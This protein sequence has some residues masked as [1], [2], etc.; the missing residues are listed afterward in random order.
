[1]K[2]IYPNS[3]LSLF[4]WM[5][6]ERLLPKL[7]AVEL[8]AGQVLYCPGERI[9]TI[10]FPHRALISFGLPLGNQSRIE[11]GLVGRRGMVGL[12]VILGGR[13]S[14]SSSAVVQ[15]GGSAMALDADALQAGFNEDSAL[16]PLLLRYTE[17]CLAQVSLLLACR[18]WH[19]VDLRFARWLLMVGDE[20]Q[21]AEIPLSQEVIAELLGI[22]QAGVK[23]AEDR[24]QLAGFISRSDGKIVVLKQPELECMACECYQRINR[25]WDRFLYWVESSRSLT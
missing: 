25:E 23:M 2:T 7:E 10:Y 22:P 17:F 5:D 21:S 13:Q 14:S 11:Q 20:L 4:P 18:S 12:A 6:Y 8:Y 3:L 19:G 16:Q 1:M 15:V 24:L 9:D